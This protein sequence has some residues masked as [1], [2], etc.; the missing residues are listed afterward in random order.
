MIFIDDG[1]KF[2]ALWYYAGGVLE[3]NCIYMSSH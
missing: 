2:G 1:N 3:E